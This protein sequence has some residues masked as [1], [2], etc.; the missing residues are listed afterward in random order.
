M[1]DGNDWKLT[2]EK[3]AHLMDKKQKRKRKGIGSYHSFP[4]AHL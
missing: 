2:M 1:T 4:R 3:T